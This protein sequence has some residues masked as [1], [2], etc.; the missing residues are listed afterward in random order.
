MLKVFQL[1]AARSTL[2]IGV[3]DIG[4]CLDLSRTTISRIEQQ[5]N[6][7]YINI[8]KLQNDLLVK[9]FEDKGIIFPDEDSLY[10]KEKLDTLE[11]RDNN[12]TRFQLRGA[13]AILGFTQYQLAE[14]LNIRKSDL[15]YL[16]NLNNTSYI[17]ATPKKI[18]ENK[19]RDFFKKNEITLQNN[20]TIKLK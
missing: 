7:N 16:E 19:I 18:D 15:N 14:I 6:L 5:N 9:F 11:T 8:S 10:L 13:R 12:I 2:G 3:R 1:K 17:S 20:Y 4:Y